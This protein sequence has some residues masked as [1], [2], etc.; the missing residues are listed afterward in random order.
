MTNNDQKEISNFE[1]NKGNF[2]K[3]YKLLVQKLKNMKEIIGILENNL[4][5]KEI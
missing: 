5:E 3:D 4:L 2:P 1:Y